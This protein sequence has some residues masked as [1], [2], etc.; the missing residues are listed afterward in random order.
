MLP[1]IT[2]KNKV[3]LLSQQGSG[4]NMIRSFLNSHPDVLFFDELFCMHNPKHDWD[5]YQKKHGIIRQYLDK[6][7]DVDKKVVGFDLKY[8][9]FDIYKEEILRYAIEND[10]KVIHYL[11]DPART[12]FQPI[13]DDKKQ[14]VL[15][16]VK[17]HCKKVR[18]H[19]HEKGEIF[20]KFRYMELTHE[21][22]T[23]GK[24]IQSLRPE[25]CGQLTDF[26]GVEYKILFPVDINIHKELKV[27]L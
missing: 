25:T 17:K 11:R 5:V 3:I 19:M 10:V 13:I 6:K 8:N 24:E 15:S 21:E 22:V 4:T 12:F 14:F 2:K 7:L 18:R 20:S 1:D 27:R 23:F 16:N 26:L 9:H